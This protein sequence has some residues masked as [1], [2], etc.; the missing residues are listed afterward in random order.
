[1]P[2]LS[3]IFDTSF[4]IIL[5][6]LVL[7]ISLVV[8]YYETK[9][10]EQNHKINSMLS[11]VSSLAEETNHLRNSFS[12]LLM[13]G[14]ANFNNNSNLEINAENEENNNIIT[15]DLIT[16]S[17]ADSEGDKSEA[18]DNL[19]DVT[20]NESDDENSESDDEN[21]EGDDESTL[22]NNIIQIQ[23]SILDNGKKNIKV[24]NVDLG[25]HELPIDDSSDS[26]I[27][28][29]NLDDLLSN[30]MNCDFEE[31]NISLGSNEQQITNTNDILSINEANFNIENDLILNLHHL[32]NDV[33]IINNNIENNN[34]MEKENENTEIIEISQEDL[35]TININ[36]TN[37]EN[38]L[39]ES[40]DFKKLPINKL[41][42]IVA[43]KGLTNDTSKLKKNELL[44]LLGIE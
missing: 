37:L 31:D 17:D 19:D 9:M 34:S 30:D 6:I 4:L 25:L 41:R 18:D 22:N 1:M 35:K 23:N 38:S 42:I 44:K 5:G 24:L 29:D 2:S 26:D 40:L 16:V 33:E 43:E 12:I 3:D 27:D 15:N 20:D 14:G 36:Q 28:A 39:N 32:S 21:S 10:R 11:L 7:S 13:N 8:I